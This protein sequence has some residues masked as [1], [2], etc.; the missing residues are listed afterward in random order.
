MQDNKAKQWRTLIII[1]IVLAVVALGGIV[2]LLT[3]PSGTVNTDN[4]NSQLTTSGTPTVINKTDPLIPAMDYNPD[5]SYKFTLANLPRIDGSTSNVPL[6]SFIICELL[7]YPCEWQQYSEEGSIIIERYV[8][9]KTNDSN[10]EAI[11]KK[12]VNSTT[13]NAYVKLINGDTD[14]IFVATLPSIDE[15]NLIKEKNVELE[16]KPIAM[17]AFVF[18]DNKSNP[19]NNLTTQQVLD[20]YTGKITN[21]KDVNG[22]NA[23]LNAYHREDNSGSQELMR[24]LVLKGTKPIAAPDSIISGMIGL[25][26]R[27]ANDTEGLGYSVYYYEQFMVKNT[28]LKLLSIN[29]VYP[30]YNSLADESYPLASPVYIV[31]KKGMDVNSATYKLSQ[32]LFTKDGQKTVRDSGYVPAIK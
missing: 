20:I 25:I 22:R 16:I 1:N 10:L 27:V 19:V 26:N 13:H 17:D 6:R 32:W 12:S 9:I 15:Q 21:W 2:Y 29:G 8:D 7:G 14:I 31:T 24:T 28:N 3:R 23:K 30:S 18:I 4:T 11:R 5:V